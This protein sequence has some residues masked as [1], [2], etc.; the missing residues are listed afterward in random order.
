MTTTGSCENNVCMTFNPIYCTKALLCNFLKSGLVVFAIMDNAYD[1]SDIEHEIRN[2][3]IRTN[4][5]TR[6]FNTINC[7]K[8]V[9]IML[10]KSFCFML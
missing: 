3:F 8:S 10:F 5:L 1:N 7:L 9:K 4:T 6:K 2:L